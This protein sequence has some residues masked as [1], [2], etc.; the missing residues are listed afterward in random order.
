MPPATFAALDPGRP[1]V[2]QLRERVAAM[3]RKPAA[4]PVATLPGIASLVSLHAGATYGV[5]SASLGLALA[6]G[7]S[8][9]G[10]WV[11]FAG[12]PDFGAEAAAELGI[13]LSRTVL[14]P[15]P[16][17]HWLEVTAALVDVL[18]VVVLRPPASVSARS[19]SVLDSRLRTRSAVLVVHGHWP[20]VD[21]RLTT[22]QSTWIGP[23]HG[24]GHLEQRRARVVV[25]RGTRPTQ[26]V[27][28]TW[29]GVRRLDRPVVERLRA[30][31]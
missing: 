4:E 25:H 29:P 6:A 22:E 10:E 3:E 13:E 31:G 14:V 30:S 8:Q 11:G 1:V 26:H 28:L 23:G 15:D 19:A 2:E 21:A 20:R 5:D 24:S 18:R 12:C 17:E 27:D 9:A 7:A 16:G